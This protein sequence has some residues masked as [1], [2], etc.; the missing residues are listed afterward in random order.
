LL[1]TRQED[2][3]YVLYTHVSEYSEVVNR[4]RPQVSVVVE[5][6]RLVGQLIVEVTKQ[7]SIVGMV[8]GKGNT[9]YSDEKCPIV[10]VIIINIYI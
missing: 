10:I 3:K 7:Y 8:I 4:G 2:R 6:C 5:T 9:K 1:G